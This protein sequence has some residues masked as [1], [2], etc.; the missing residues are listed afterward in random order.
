VT[1]VTA[2]GFESRRR[3]M[4]KALSWRVLAAIITAC[5]ALA[6]TGQLAFAAKIGAL[7]TTVKL[8]IY[9]LHERIWNK[10]NYGRVPAPDYEV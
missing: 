9:F 8:L 1:P 6:M 3:S 2:V 4:V 5:V 7:D 10:I